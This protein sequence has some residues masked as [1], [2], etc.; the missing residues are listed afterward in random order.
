MNKI[1][2]EI[3]DSNAVKLSVDGKASVDELIAVLMSGLE[4]VIKTFLKE[5]DDHDTL[6][7]L[8]DSM[9]AL[10]F[11]FMEKVFPDVQPRQFD[12][13][14]AAM[15]YA[16]DCIISEASK[17][18]ISFEEA[19]QKYEDKARAYVNARLGGVS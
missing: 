15:L 1:T 9:D 17:E 11:R 19:M 6:V 2:L 3:N 4:A 5:V 13:S 14:D 7:D 10:F 16:Q 18:V 8:Y 12:F